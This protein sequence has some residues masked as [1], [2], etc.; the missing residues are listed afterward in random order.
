MAIKTYSQ[1]RTSQYEL[2]LEKMELLNPLGILKKGYAVVSKD[3][4][5]L[6]DVDN[7]KKNDTI[8]IRLHRGSII[9]KV[10]E[11]KEI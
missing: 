8:N 9:A 1:N 2:L 3:D 11:T 7:L 6:T 10:E 5:T 4:A